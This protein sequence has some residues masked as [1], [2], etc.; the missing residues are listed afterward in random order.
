MI[1]TT[2]PTIARWRI[3]ETMGLVRGNTIQTRWIGRDIAAGLRTIVGGEIKG[4]TALISRA[5][6]EAVRR[7]VLQAEKKGANAIIGI[8]FA[9]STVMSG[10]AEILAYGTAVR[11]VKKEKN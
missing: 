2:V 8:R 4:Y 7:M 5:R 9:S 11:I 6:Q 1:L 10:A 3:V